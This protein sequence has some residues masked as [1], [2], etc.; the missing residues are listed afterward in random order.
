[1]TPKPVQELVPVQ[2]LNTGELLRQ[3]YNPNKEFARWYWIE[4]NRRFA[5]PTACLVLVLIG[6]PLG[7]SAKKGGKG[8]GFVLTIVLVFIYYFLYLIGLNL[9]RSGRLPPIAGVWMA[10]FIFAVLGLLLLWRTDKMPI[11]IGLGQ[12]LKSQLKNLATTILRENE[13][14]TST[15]ARQ[16]SRLFNPRFPLIL[17]DYVLRSFIRYL[18]LILSS[19]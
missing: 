10:N 5:L 14:E 19:L 17:D 8:A 18:V 1:P 4:F 7:L 15:G 2:Q 16:R 11:E 13:D 9:A 12:A 6:I 3:T